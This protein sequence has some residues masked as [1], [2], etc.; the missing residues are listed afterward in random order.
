ML[1]IDF[2]RIMLTTA[3]PIEMIEQKVKAL[4]RVIPQQK[5]GRWM[6]PKVGRRMAKSFH[7]VYCDN[8]GFDFDIMQNESMD[9]MKY[10]PNCG[11]KM[12][13]EYD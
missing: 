6:V 5:V 10:C 3:K 9:K 13:G 2:E 12:E 4:P 7:K 8:C 11:A 1:D